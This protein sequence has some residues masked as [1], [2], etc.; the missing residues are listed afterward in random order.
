MPTP[1]TSAWKRWLRQPQAFWLRR[2]L[3]QVHL[4]SGIAVGLYVIAICVSGSVL[5]YR[6]ELRQTFEPQPRFV[7]VSGT[8]LSQDELTAAAEG[9]YPGWAVSRRWPRRS[10]VLGVPRS[11]I[12]CSW[13]PSTPTPATTSATG[14]RSPTG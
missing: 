9:A 11:S 2:A 5:V 1:D 7:T 13:V 3:F 6:S 4:W 14:C 8:R 12:H 10:S